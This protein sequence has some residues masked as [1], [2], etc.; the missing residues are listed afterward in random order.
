MIK[1]INSY[2]SIFEN[3]NKTDSNIFSCYLGLQYR[4]LYHNRNHYCNQYFNKSVIY[5]VPYLQT[6][7]ETLGMD[8]LD[9]DSTKIDTL[10]ESQRVLF[11]IYLEIQKC[12]IDYY[13]QDS[14]RLKNHVPTKQSIILN[15]N[16]ST[17]TC[18]V[19][20][21]ILDEY[22]DKFTSSI[23]LNVLNKLKLFFNISSQI[24]I[25][26][27]NVSEINNDKISSH[28]HDIRNFESAGILITHS[29]GTIRDCSS[30]TAIMNNGRLYDIKANFQKLN[31]P[32][33]LQ[34]ID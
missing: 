3:K 18:I 22:L 9:N 29:K 21:V 28:F 27:K 33:Q 11:N 15:K 12:F 20:V 7:F 24:I 25:N 16:S 23:R 19:L 5:S 26:K 2:D 1:K 32:A 13:C 31:Y 14:N 30:R 34:L 4:E 10:L 17:I 8:F 6:A